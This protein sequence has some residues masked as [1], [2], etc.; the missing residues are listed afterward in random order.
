MSATPIHPIPHNVD[1][2][3]PTG[4]ACPA[5]ASPGPVPGDVVLASVPPRHGGRGRPT[6]TPCLVLDVADGDSGPRAL[7]VPGVPATG[8]RAR[9]DDLYATGLDLGGVRDLRGPHVFRGD[10]PLSV[11]L[12]RDGTRPDAEAGVVILGRLGGAAGR[13]L[14]A[15]RRCLPAEREARDGARAATPS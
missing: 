11:A 13:K 3:H 4:C 10:R 12:G 9:R 15:L 1:A 7:V 5:C 8:R 2:P 14:E 6:P